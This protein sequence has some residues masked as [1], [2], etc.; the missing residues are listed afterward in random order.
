MNALQLILQIIE[1]AAATASPFLN[2]NPEG[3]AIDAVAEAL[4]KIA[5]SALGAY[6]QV[7]G[8]PMDLSTLQ[9]IE[10]VQ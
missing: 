6:Q 8:K 7:T 10:P 4:A 9:P 5:A 1:T 3:Q 2:G